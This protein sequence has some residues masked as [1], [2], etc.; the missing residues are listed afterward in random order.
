MWID[1]LVYLETKIYNGKWAK[2]LVSATGNRTRA[3][4][5]RASYPNH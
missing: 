1:M 4:W 3:C 5:V 2:R